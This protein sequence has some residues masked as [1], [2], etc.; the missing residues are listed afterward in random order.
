MADESAGSIFVE[1]NA[2]LDGLQAEVRK[3]NK[4]IHDLGDRA[5]DASGRM[6]F[7]FSQMGKDIGKSFTNLKNNTVNQFAQMATGIQKAFMALPIIGFITMVT[8][9]IAKLVGGINDYLNKTAEAYSKQQKELASLNAVVKTTGAYAWTSSAQL[10]SM[11]DNLSKATGYA[12]NDITQMQT[13]ILTYTNIIGEN[14]ERT[15]KAAIDMAAVMGMDLSSAAETLGKALDSPIE[16]LSAL[17]R[18]GFRFKDEMKDQIK[19]LT[20]QGKISEAQALILKEVES[21]YRGVAKE[22]SSV[23]SKTERLKQ[24]QEELNAEVGRTTSKFTNFVAGLKLSWKESQLFEMR[25]KRIG[26]AAKDS[27]SKIQ[28][29]TKNIADLKKTLDELIAG[30]ANE[31]RIIR[32]RVQIE[33]AEAALNRERANEAAILSRIERWENENR[34]LNAT[35]MDTVQKERDLVVLK[36]QLIDME[37]ELGT[38]TGNSARIKQNDILFQKELIN[39]TE[40]L[41]AENRELLNVIDEQLRA[42]YIDRNNALS[43]QKIEEE[44]IETNRAI[45]TDTAKITALTEAL[46]AAEKKRADTIKAA[47][48][49]KKDERITEEELHQQT[50]AAYTEEANQITT[51]RRQISELSMQTTEG[52]AS[53]ASA[54]NRTNTALSAAIELERQ[55][56]QLLADIA[57][58]KAYEN[59]QAELERFGKSKEALFELD[60]ERAWKEIED[61]KDYI[62]ATEEK[63]QAVKRLFDDISEGYRKLN[64]ENDS[65]K[66]MEKFKENIGKIQQYVSAV[67]NFMS[68][69]TGLFISL[70]QKSTDEELKAL[71]KL[72]QA[73]LD[74]LEKE[75]QA[76]LY[77][78]GFIEAQTEEQHQRE[79]EL[80][81]ESGDQQRIYEAHNNYERFLI[82]DEF[83]KNKEALDQETA[84]KKAQLEYKSALATWQGQLLQ[85]AA[86]GIQAILGTM[87]SPPYPPLN[88]ALI[89]LTTGA[90]AANLA[91]MAAAKPKLQF[92]SGGIVPGDFMRGDKV[93][94]SLNSGEMILNRKQQQ[95]MFDAINNGEIGSGSEK[96]ITVNVPVYLD[97]K[98]ITKIV[99]DNINNRTDLIQKGSIID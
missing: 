14:F 85:A 60:R 9:A 40:R 29:Y 45:I 80:A 78:K 21:V 54:I 77:A 33:D 50:L 13:R 86:T 26:E 7:S 71:E 12:K 98:L 30:G 1:I 47:E 81:I 20:E 84:H 46:T 25:Q 51:L 16:G 75:K 32:I 63:R 31:E 70:I 90:V 19:L 36:Q 76:K 43:N 53:K 44:R 52:E 57:M 96:N 37:I 92:N 65:E 49:A 74:Y 94:A 4:I 99:V 48:E 91:L 35:R 79:L 69:M 42:A 87:A 83:A 41:V 93:A 72:Y 38:L 73:K 5:N 82:E 8:G 97:G 88:A 59:M 27:E 67:G 55:Q 23:S 10:K 95:N 34:R 6:N 64:S 3:A 24:V 17:T 11:A 28:S 2:K 39:N 18:Q 62:N 66:A 15:S 89:A 58:D 61:S 22:Q 56:K 68:N